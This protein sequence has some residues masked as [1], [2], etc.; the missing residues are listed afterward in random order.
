MCF[1]VGEGRTSGDA[2]APDELR[3][4]RG[5]ATEFSVIAGGVKWDSGGLAGSLGRPAAS[6]SRAPLRR[7]G[8]DLRGDVLSGLVC[9]WSLLKGEGRA[10]RR[11]R[12]SQI[13]SFEHTGLTILQRVTAHT[14]HTHAVGGRT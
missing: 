4:R 9:L 8:V 10:K 12:H 5:G 14:H 3:Q 7:S 6:A 2:S 11:G 13:V 1:H